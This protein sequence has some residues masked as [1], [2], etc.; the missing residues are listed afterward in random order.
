MAFSRFSEEIIQNKLYWIT[1]DCT[2]LI[3]KKT[4]ASDNGYTS[5]ELEDRAIQVRFDLA[6]DASALESTTLDLVYS[7]FGAFHR[8][9]LQEVTGEYGITT[10]NKDFE[11]IS[12]SNQNDVRQ[13]LPSGTPV[14]VT[15]FVSCCPCCWKWI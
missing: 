15:S 4:F 9:A 2:K 10:I 1:P 13:Q 7:S 12:I 6:I 3:D 5:D 8:T 14:L 11:K